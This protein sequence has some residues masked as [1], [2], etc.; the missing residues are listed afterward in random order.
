M[1][2]VRVKAKVWN[3][4]NPENA[5]EVLLLVDTGAIYTVLPR[6][7]LEEMGIKNIGKRKFKLANNQ[8]VERDVGIIGIEIQ[9]IHAHTLAVFGDEGTYLLGATT[10]EELGLEVDPVKRELRPMEHLLMLKQA[11]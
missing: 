1:A 9:G 5:R 8:V 3:V 10:L 6:S 11:P 7:L 2:F 4:E